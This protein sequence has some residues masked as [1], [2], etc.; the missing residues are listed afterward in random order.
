MKRS[1]APVFH[2]ISEVVPGAGG[3]R[4]LCGH[5]PA[6]ETV[7]L[8]SLSGPMLIILGVLLLLT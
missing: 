1:P 8:Q 7:A 2:L 3:A 5:G 4:L 6:D